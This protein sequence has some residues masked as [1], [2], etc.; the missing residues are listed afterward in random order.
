MIIS[1]TL[2]YVI[3]TQ[4]ILWGLLYFQ[5]ELDSV[6][7]TLG[8]G[9]HKTIR[10]HLHYQK[11]NCKAVCLNISV[12][13]TYESESLK[14]NRVYGSANSGNPVGVTTNLTDLI[15]LSVSTFF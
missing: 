4:A 1:K 3:C 12:C 7:I 10:R 11:V 15:H 14:Q 2:L 5:G 9:Q 13:F 8:N 6:E